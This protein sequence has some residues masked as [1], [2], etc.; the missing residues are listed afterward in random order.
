MLDLPTH[1]R[2]ALRRCPFVRLV[3]ADRIAEAHALAAAG[4]EPAEPVVA[5]WLVVEARRQLALGGST[6]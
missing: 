5:A 1:S 2:A 6:P 3:A 4:P